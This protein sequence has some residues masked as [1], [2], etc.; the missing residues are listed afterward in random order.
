MDR[1]F[2]LVKLQKYIKSLQ[3]LNVLKHNIKKKGRYDMGLTQN[4]ETVLLKSKRHCALC[5]KMLLMR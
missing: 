2:V 1:E 5:E 4:K 3:Y